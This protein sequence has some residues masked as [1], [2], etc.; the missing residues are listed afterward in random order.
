[1]HIFQILLGALAGCATIFTLAAEFP[2]VNLNNLNNT[3]TG[4][5]IMEGMALDC[6][7]GGNPIYDS[8]FAN[9]TSP[10]VLDCSHLLVG[11]GDI[12]VRGKPNKRIDYTLAYRTCVFTMHLVLGEW[13]TLSRNQI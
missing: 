2:I 9:S 10:Y 12:T 4:D 5:L 7:A 1:M 6:K 3:M 8:V 13:M 11:L